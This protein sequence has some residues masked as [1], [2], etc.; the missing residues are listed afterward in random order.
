MNTVSDEDDDLLAASATT[1]VV[2]AVEQR[3]GSLER[4][5]KPESKQVRAQLGRMGT[6][7]GKHSV[8]V[9]V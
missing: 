2:V 8:S 9:R 4:H 1:L 7:V 6:A 5:S 3:E